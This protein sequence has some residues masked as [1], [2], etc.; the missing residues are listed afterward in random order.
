[1][2]RLGCGIYLH[3]TKGNPMTR[4]LVTGASGGIGRKT[5]HHLLKFRPAAQLVGLVRDPA[6][7]QDLAALG[8]ELRR[9]DY[10]DTA[11][12]SA[13]FEGIEKVMLISTHAFTPRNE[14][15]ANGLG[16]PSISRHSRPPRCPRTCARSS[17]NGF[18][19]WPPANGRTRPVTSRS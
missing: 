1:M 17:C 4:I 2:D 13:A 10:L 3:A 11:S 6:K 9:G 12:L 16:A 8:I 15:H 7:A 19:A 5:L 14:A 18:R